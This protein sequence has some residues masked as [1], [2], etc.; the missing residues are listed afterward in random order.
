[1]GYHFLTQYKHLLTNVY[2]PLNIFL[3]YFLKI[4]EVLSSYFSFLL[5]YSSY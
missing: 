5:S 1:M 3:F 2:C 4:I